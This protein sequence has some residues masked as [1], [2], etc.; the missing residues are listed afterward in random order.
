MAFR[1]VF[2][3]GYSLPSVIVLFY[4]ATLRWGCGALL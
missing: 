2:F 3:G 1:D 4:Y